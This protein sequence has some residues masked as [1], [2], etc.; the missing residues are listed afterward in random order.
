MHPSH[1]LGID[2]VVLGRRPEESDRHLR[3][4]YAAAA[5]DALASNLRGDPADGPGIGESVRSG[6]RLNFALHELAD[7][8]H[9]DGEIVLSLQVDPELRRVAE[10]TAKT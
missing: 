7:I 4:H 6:G 1:G 9:G 2:S 5:R 3:F 8:A 10:I